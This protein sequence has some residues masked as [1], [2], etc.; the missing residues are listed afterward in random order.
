MEPR[1]S[2]GREKLL[3]A[4][5]SCS[6]GSNAPFKTSPHDWTGCR[7]DCSGQRKQQRAGDQKV[8]VIAMENHN[9]TQL[10]N[11]FTGG[12]QQI[13]QNWRRPSSTAW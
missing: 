2:A 6:W 5:K 8:F 11:Q 7:P 13:Y 4:R 1:T 10:T 12:I 9:W 3:D